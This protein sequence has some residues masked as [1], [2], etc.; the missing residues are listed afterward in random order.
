MV[1]GEL[2]Q[3]TGIRGIPFTLPFGTCGIK[4]GRR[5]AIMKESRHNAISS[6]LAWYD[7][8]M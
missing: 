7:E 1:F 8:W 4:E 6:W 2:E 5:D 3:F